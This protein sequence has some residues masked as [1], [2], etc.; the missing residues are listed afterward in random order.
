M[1]TFAFIMSHHSH[2]NATFNLVK[3]LAKDNHRIIFSGPRFGI[4]GHDLQSS[5]IK[6]GFEFEEIKLYNNPDDKNAFNSYAYSLA[7]GI[8]FKKFTERHKPDVVFLDIHYSIFAIPFWELVKK[9][10]L[11]STE[12]STS[13]NHQNLPLTIDRFPAFRNPKEN[14]K[15]WKKYYRT[16][17]GR[18][19]IIAF[20][21]K[22]AE[23]HNH[24][25]FSKLIDANRC[26]IPFSFKLPE[27]IL[28]PKGFDTLKGNNS[29]GVY[30]GGH[31]DIS[32]AETVPEEL[33]KIPLDKKLIYVALG[34]R[35][36]INSTMK[37]HLLNMLIDV[38]SKMPNIYAIITGAEKAVSSHNITI[39]QNAP[40]LTILKRCDLMIT[41]A[42]GNSVKECIYFKVPMLCIP[43]DNDQFGIAARVEHFKIGLKLSNNTGAR[44]Q[45]KTKIKKLLTNPL[46]KQNLAKQKRIFFNSK[47][48]IHSRKIIIKILSNNSNNIAL[49]KFL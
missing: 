13:E 49:D 46:F 38:L 19:N 20:A 40:Q 27:I 24:F 44:N 43:S 21:S 31:V 36:E 33:N 15:A 22:V 47:H 45:I 42:G 8:P 26:V 32:R 10:V 7:T 14:L 35:T 30:L 1:A 11:V 6:Q 48:Q 4:D 9:I 28:W 16:N 12:L 2:Q 5:V 29:Q 17:S 41:H 3:I 23:H 18:S 39:L 37:Q 25:P 34:T